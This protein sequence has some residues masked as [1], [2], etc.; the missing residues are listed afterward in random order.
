MKKLVLYK[1]LNSFFL[2]RSRSGFRHACQSNSSSKKLEVSVRVVLAL[3]PEPVKE[4]VNRVV[5]YCNVKRR[6]A[7]REDKRYTV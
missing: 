5:R 7:D 1:R 6:A 4:T 2:E 3:S